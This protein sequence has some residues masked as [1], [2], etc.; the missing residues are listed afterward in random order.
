MNHINPKMKNITFQK[1]EIIKRLY[2]LD[3][4]S[5]YRLYSIE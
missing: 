5:N 2:E 3:S 1:N 4:V